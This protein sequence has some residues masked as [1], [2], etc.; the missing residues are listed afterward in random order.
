MTKQCSK[1]LVEKPTSEFRARPERGGQLNSSCRT[2]ETTHAREYR[3]KHPDR[4]RKSRKLLYHKPGQREKR[5][6]HWMK[7]R[8]GMT[9]GERNHMYSE[10]NGCCPICGAPAE[11]DRM[12]I[13]HDHATGQVRALLCCSCN[14]FVGWIE[15]RRHLLTTALEYLDGKEETQ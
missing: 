7:W 5:K 13:D 1:C 4:V 6:A 14:W 2:C 10:Q 11:L 3:H 9:V 15:T 8:Y 12:H